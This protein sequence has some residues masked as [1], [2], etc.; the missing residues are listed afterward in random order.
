MK[1]VQ[2]SIF[3]SAIERYTSLLLLFFSTAMLSRLLT[4]A[5]FGIFAVINALTA[6]VA[7][8]FQEFGGANY[9][10]QKQQ[11]SHANIRTAFTVTLAISALVGVGF[12]ALAETLSRFFE[13]ASLT[14]GIAVSS[15][16]FLLVPFSGTLSALFR[17]N[18][19]FGKLAICNL[20]ANAAIALVS[21]G[22][23]MAGFSYM[24][25]IWGSV[26]GNLLLTVM[27][28][29]WNRDLSMFRPSL[30][31]HRDVVGFGLY[32]SGV[33]IINVFYSLSPQLFLAKILDFASVGLYS[34]AINITQMFDRL[35]MQVL[36][37]V[38]MPALVAQRTSGANL[39]RV[40]L[41][42][43]ELLS[44]VQWPFLVFVAI[45][46]R[47]IILIWLG[48]NWLEIVPLVRL[49][50]IA[51][52]ALFAACLSYPMLVAVGSVRDALVSSFISLPPSL[53]V[54]LCAS[55]FGVQAV[56]ASALLTLPFQAAVAIYFLSRHL[57]IRPAELAR[58]LLRSCVVTVVTAC[59][60][61][62]CAAL[63]DAG[64]LTPFVGLI[65]AFG[66]AA[67]CWWLALVQTGHPL[68][69]RFYHAVGDLAVIAP[70]LRSWRAAA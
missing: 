17:R 42:A 52:L 12:F 23:A 21:I 24:A 22:L 41:E 8:S 46:A 58:P 45:M 56:A 36:N 54:I 43:I 64:M 27:L 33:V 49:L 25:P 69:D 1:S 34:R 30:V 10:I 53:I 55:F 40:Y 26:A 63:I 16:N 18:M 29:A 3:F 4:P 66:V 9:L 31:E 20:G 37:P 48:Q 62:G 67:L 15:L 70:W 11:L 44:A 51:N 60:V 2:S 5:E 47:S 14:R 32:S 28:L 57:A 50:C 35:V 6:V 39:K 7:A 65:A 59:G 13:Q 19:E 68:R 61:G 38:I